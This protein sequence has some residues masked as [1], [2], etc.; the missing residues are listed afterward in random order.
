[1]EIKD[2]ID[3]IASMEETSTEPN[4]EEILSEEDDVIDTLSNSDDN[5]AS[6]PINGDEEPEEDQLDDE[7]TLRETKKKKTWVW[8]AVNWKW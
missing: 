2:E 3:S 5:D 1:M 8:E 7:I 4:F 6:E